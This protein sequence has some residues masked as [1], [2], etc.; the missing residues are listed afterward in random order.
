L[1]ERVTRWIIPLL[2]NQSNNNDTKIK[3]RRKGNSRPMGKWKKN[4]P[5]KR[6]GP[7]NGKQT[8]Y[9]T[10]PL[11]GDHNVK[12]LSYSKAVARYSKVLN[13]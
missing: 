1:G 2:R 8:Y 9:N 13:R 5:K 11:L 6:M 12:L 4:F 10:N 7:G 3:R